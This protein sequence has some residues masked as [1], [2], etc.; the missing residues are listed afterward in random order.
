MKAAWLFFFAYGFAAAAGRGYIDLAPFGQIM[1]WPND[2]PAKAVTLRPIPGGIS[3]FGLQW[4]EERDVREIRIQYAGAAPDRARLEY[5]FKN[6]PYAPPKMPTIEDPLDDP[7]QGKWLPA[8]V[9]EHCTSLECVYT[10]QALSTDEN[11]LAKNLPGVSYRRTLKVRFT[12]GGPVPAVKTIQAYSESKEKPV[13]VRVELGGRDRGEWSG[14]IGVFNG[15]LRSARGWNFQAGDGVDS[16]GNWRL[17]RNGAGK[18]LILDLAASQPAP[19]GSH[20]I[21]IVTVRMDQ[22]A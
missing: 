3:N 9:V 19:P 16:A 1:T 4:D 14:N 21:T 18:G 6:W 8:Q 13:R 17:R 7:W 12:F 11:P 20:D 15:A 22:A 10:F 5:W 2:G